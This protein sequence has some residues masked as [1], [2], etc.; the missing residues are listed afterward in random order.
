MTVTAVKKCMCKTVKHHSGILGADL[1]SINV[2]Q[3]QSSQVQMVAHETA[4]AKAK[5][6]KK[7]SKKAKVSF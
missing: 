4:I 6:V 3:N 7:G 2:P 1:A 5:A